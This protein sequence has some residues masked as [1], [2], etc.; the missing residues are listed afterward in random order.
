MDLQIDLFDMITYANVNKF[1]RYVDCFSKYAWAVPIKD[2]AGATIAD[3]LQAIFFVEGPPKILQSDNGLEFK[4]AE[5]R[6][7]CARFNI[8]QRFGREYRP[9]S[10]GQVFFFLLYK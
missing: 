10:Q 7:L 8:E 5:V 9:Q 4:N 3:S 2:K 6:A 1:F